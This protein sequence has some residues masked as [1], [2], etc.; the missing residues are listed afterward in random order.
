MTVHSLV[1]AGAYSGL[2]SVLLMA[3]NLSRD[4]ALAHTLGRSVALDCFLLASMVPIFAVSVLTG[5]FRSIVV[6][7]IERLEAG[8]SGG[9]RLLAPLILKAALTTLL[10][11]ALIAILFPVISPLISGKLSKDAGQEIVRIGWALLPMFAIS[12][13]AS[14]ADGP[15]QTK[16]NYFYPLVARSALPIGIAIAVL[17]CG[18]RFGIWAAIYGGTLGALL[19]LAITRIL[20]YRAWG[21]RQTPSRNSVVQSPPLLRE[22][23]YLCGGVSILYVSPLVDQTMASMLGEGAVSALGYAS[24]ISIGISSLTIGLVA[25]ALLPHFSRLAVGAERQ[26]LRQ[27]YLAATSAAI[28]CGF[29]LAIGLWLFSEPGVVLLYERGKF[30]SNDSRAVAE[31]LRCIGLQFPFLLAGIVSA[32][33][34]SAL[35]KNRIFVPL[36]IAN[37]VANILGNWSLMGPFGLNG[38]AIAT[39]ITYALSMLTMLFVIQRMQNTAL[40]ATVMRHFIIAGSGAAA[41]LAL[42]AYFDFTPSF[43]PSTYQL[44][45]STACLTLFMV[46]AYAVNRSFFRQQSNPGQI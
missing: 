27:H 40:F 31:V 20:V 10:V 19:H 42:G 12:G 16:G 17:M 37:V 28:W 22:Y 23:L 38:I 35:E 46:G 4:M 44:G 32:N 3:A 8:G 29:A 5:A 9:V 34:I 45:V 36:N 43:N 2:G 14:L 39:V 11:T 6:P 26:K 30:D 13:F 25:P 7:M 21:L 1:R 24:R 18:P 41:I 15:L 33:L